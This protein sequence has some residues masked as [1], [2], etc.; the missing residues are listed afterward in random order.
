VSLLARILACLML[1]LSA[2]AA[3]SA[4]CFAHSENA[5]AAIRR[6]INE[7]WDK[8]D[9]KVIIDP[10]VRMGDHAV[11]GWIQ[12]ERG[13]RA[14]VRRRGADWEV[15]LCSGDPLK[16]ASTMMAAGVPTE[17]AAALE[18]DLAEAEAKLPGERAAMLSRFEGVVEVG[19]GGHHGHHK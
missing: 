15:V 8:P 6:V 11:A 5:D 12:G 10:V 13:G 3:G 18:K 2:L 9:A 1:A 14:L 7:T 4:P 19:S 17:V 16:H